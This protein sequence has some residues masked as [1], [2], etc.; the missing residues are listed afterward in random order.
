VTQTVEVNVRTISATI[1][2][3]LLATQLV[4]CS[5]DGSDTGV[6]QPT[7]QPGVQQT[8]WSGT[9]AGNPGWEHIT[10]TTNVQQVVNASEFTATAM[11]Q[12]D[13]S[14]AERPWHVH[15]DTCESGG[16]IV[17]GDATYPRLMVGADG[18]AT[19]SVTVPVALDPEAR[20]HVNVHISS[21][22]LP[23]LIA[24]GDL[25]LPGM[26]PPDDEPPDDAPPVIDY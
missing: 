15:F 16:G 21:A 25:L 6:R 20:Y 22:D 10:G 24:C 19:S 7:D 11:I 8:N 17:G 14:G 12:G 13:Q 4:A 5:D 26:A 9:I 2:G 1:I 18:M 23:T 3:T